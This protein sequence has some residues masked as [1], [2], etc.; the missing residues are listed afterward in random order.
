MALSIYQK[1]RPKKFSEI[2]GQNYIVKILSNSVANQRTAN[3]YLFTGSHG[4]GKTTLARIFSKAVNCLDLQKQK[5]SEIKIEPC[6]KCKNCKLILKNQAIDLNEIDAASHTGVDNIRQLKEN[7]FTP[8]VALNYKVYI[9]DEVHMLSLGAFNALLKILEEPPAH[10]IFILATTE[11]HKVPDTILS[12]CQRFD[13]QRLS[14]KEIAQ[15]LK[16]LA[17]KEGVKIEQAALENIAIESE[18]GMRNAESLLGQIIAFKE[19]NI[20][21]EDVNRIVGLSSRKT[22][23]DFVSGLLKGKVKNNLNTIS[24]MQNEGVNLKNFNRL[25]LYFLRIILLEKAGSSGKDNSGIDISPEQKKQVRELAEKISYQDLLMA[26]KL[27]QK[28]I[29][30]F[31]DVSMLQLP[32]EL[33]AIEFNLY[34]TV[35]KNQK[36]NSAESSR[37][38][39]NHQNQAE[40]RQNEEKITPQESEKKN[41]TEALSAEKKGGA[42]FSSANKNDSSEE[43]NKQK[44]NPV[45]EENQSK[46]NTASNQGLE[47]ERVLDNWSKIL[48]AVKPYNHSIHAFLKNCSPLCIQQEK[49]FIKTKYDFYKARLNEHNNKLTI[50]QVVDKIVSCDLQ[51]VICTE[52]EAEKMNLENNSK[53]KNHNVLHDAMQMM[54]GRIVE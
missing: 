21:A 27:F 14:Q 12:R 35:P 38:D 37:P 34:S 52:K 45:V 31:K 47:I 43:I 6:N 1:Y 50:K 36:E 51:I 33:A 24:R 44:K 39:P 11:V 46:T 28:N 3:A 18:G 54:G 15:R 42:G 48:E 9:I 40:V 20:T 53:G 26:A 49:L 29:S 25:V 19:N 32:L 4:T 17:K 30:L 2:S 22:V 16:Q 23:L 5:K 7:V 13:F 8:P 10:A 41:T